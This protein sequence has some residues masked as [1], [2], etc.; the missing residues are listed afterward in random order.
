MITVICKN[1]HENSPEHDPDNSWGDDAE[2]I[3]D[4]KEETVTLKCRSCKGRDMNREIVYSIK[5]L[6]IIKED[7]T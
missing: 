4:L 7:K 5:G 3:I 2:L 6:K 1:G